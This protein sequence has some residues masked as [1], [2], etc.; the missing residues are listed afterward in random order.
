MV[1]ITILGSCRQDSLYSTYDVT[2]IKNAVSYPHYTKE[3]IEV[4]KFCKFG[5]V[6]PEDTLVTFR[7]PGIN[8]KPLFFSNKLKEEF[9]S[10]DIFF[11]EIASRK[12]YM[13]NGKYVHHIFYDDPKYNLKTKDL[14]NTGILSDEEIENDILEIKNLL[15][16][17]II[18][19][20]HLITQNEGSRYE[21]GKL[22]KK[23]CTKH[24]IIF[25]N[26]VEE[27]IKSNF[28]KCGIFLQED[29]LAHYSQKGHEVIKKIYDAF[30]LN[31][32]T[33]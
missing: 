17:P 22:L 21:L 11:I 33:S 15:K 8:N 32:G 25:I 27:I 16:K 30:I 10:S 18:I 28:D 29:V 9:E 31:I 14:I 6:K 3:I 1:K 23:I 7:T 13:L 24:D 12:T 26:P 5:N 20:S 2:S 19:V 4:I